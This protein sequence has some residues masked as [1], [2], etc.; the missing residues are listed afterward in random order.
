MVGGCENALLRVPSQARRQGYH[1][2]IMKYEKSKS[3]VATFHC[4]FLLCHIVRL[5][6]PNFLQRPGRGTISALV[7]SYSLVLVISDRIDTF[8][9]HPN[10]SPKA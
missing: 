10:P 9:D 2:D 5:L 7:D 8:L 4:L 1:Y 6:F 3:F